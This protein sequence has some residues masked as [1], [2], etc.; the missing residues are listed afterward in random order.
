[1]QA[2]DL[3]PQSAIGGRVSGIGALR[4]DALEVKLAS[5]FME[6]G[7]V[8]A[9]I[10]AVVEG[11]RDAR[12]QRGEPRL[13]LDQRPRADIVAVEMQKIEEE[14]HQPGRVAGV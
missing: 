9:V 8:A 6:R 1:V 2:F 3:D 7:A 11:R 14:M 4:D 10:V 12:Q 13:A 5:L